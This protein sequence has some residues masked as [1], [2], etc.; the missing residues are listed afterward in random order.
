MIKYHKN[1]YKKIYRSTKLFLKFIENQEKINGKTII[2][3]GCGA[4]ANTLYMAKSFKK[5]K[6]IGLD[7]DRELIN[8][9]N[10]I[11][12]INKI[13]NCEFYNCDIKQIKKIRKKIPRKI[14]IVLSFHVMSF[15]DIWYDEF[16]KKTIQLN[17]KT[18][19]HSSLFYDGF[20]ELKIYA[21]DFSKNDFNGS[22]YNIFSFKKIEDFLKKRNFYNFKKKIMEIDINLKKPK[23]GGMGSY[24]LN[25]KNNKKILKSGPI[26]LPWGYFYSRKN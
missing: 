19:A 13:K 2:D 3:V 14:D 15:L 8:H 16:L 11:V 23:H 18:I 4:G 24:T 12:K 26:S 10:K 5:S 17:P 9:A 21:T 6:I 7:K 22:Y 1:Q 20:A 25:L